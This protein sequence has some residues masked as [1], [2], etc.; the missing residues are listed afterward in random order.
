MANVIKQK[1]GTGT[2]TG[3]MVKSELAIKHVAA[4]ATAANSSMLYIGEDA[5]DD[6]VT[7]RAL[8][9]GMTGDSG[10][11]GAAIGN[12]MTFTGGTD[13]TT[14]V[15]GSTV[16]ITSSA[17]GGSGDMTGVDITAD[18]GLDISQSNTTSGNYTSTISLDLSELSDGTADIDSNDEVIYLDNGTEKRKAFSEL[19]LS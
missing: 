18:T 10:Q 3:G 15:S 9:T 4:N 7:I 1:S 6:G 19:K 5:G 16:T 8:G 12:S 11:G 14:S 17:G 13:I 2:P